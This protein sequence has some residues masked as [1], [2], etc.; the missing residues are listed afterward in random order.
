MVVAVG[1]TLVEPVAEVDVKVPGE[2]EIFDAPVVDQ[3]SVLLEPDFMV[4]GLALNEV[5]IGAEPLPEGEFEL[6]QLTSM[7]QENEIRANTRR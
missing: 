5:I 1:L 7:A 3:L 2:I 4:A 6:L